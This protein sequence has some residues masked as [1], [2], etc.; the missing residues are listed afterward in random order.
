VIQND[1]VI[2]FQVVARDITAQKAAEAALQEANGKMAQSLNELQQRNHEIILLNEMS[3]QLQVCE[4]A[5]AA[6]GVIGDMTKQLF[7]NT[8]GAL[9]LLNKPHALVKA[10]ATWGK[11][12]SS[13]Q[14]FASDDCWALRR[15]RTHPLSED[16]TEPRCLHI[17]E[18]LPAVSYCLPMQAQG[19]IIG[20]LHLR[21][22]S[23]ENL[24]EPKRQLA[25]SIVD[26]AGM[27]ISN[28][29]LREALREQSI[30][31]PLTGLFNRR[32]M[33]AALKQQLSRVTRHLHPLG[34]IMI[35]VDHFKRFNDTHGHAAGDVLLRELGKFLQSH[36]RYEDIA[37]RYGGEEF[38]LILPD[39][40]LEGV[41]QRAEYLRLNA[42][43][44]QM[45][46]A[47]RS[48][49][50][51]TVSV[52][53]AVYPRMAEQSRLCCAPLMRRSIAPKR[54]AATAS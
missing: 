26:Q 40:A 53:V 12:S 29:R 10:T 33:E 7:P 42:T 4:S 32:Y 45:P 48:L 28:L 20:V 14:T 3:S 30:R 16:P 18:P 27:A 21:S 47:G 34:I 39:A 36:I 17:S 15:G 41:R 9:Y 46:D 54:A 50:G 25:Y 52:G 23:K 49:E 13:D 44:L 37:C 38:I 1:R 11:L 31:D 5:E 43:K 35:D 24:G 22:K 2:G 51:I 8:T 19:E 6:Y